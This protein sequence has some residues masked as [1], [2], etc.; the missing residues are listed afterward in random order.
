MSPLGEYVVQT[1]VTLV[2]IAI[3]AW[4]VITFGRRVGLP[5][6]EGTLR[7]RGRLALDARRSVYLV[8]V[9]DKVLV[10]GA[11]EGGISKLA[12]LPGNALPE[13]QAAPQLSF[14]EVLARVGVGKPKASVEV[15]PSSEEER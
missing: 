14:S 8:E 1:A 12:E 3:L 6:D 7:L 11:G 10:L 2:G 15:A 5:K 4:L 9:G 13:R